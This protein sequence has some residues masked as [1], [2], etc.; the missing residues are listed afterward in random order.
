MI[1]KIDILLI[2]A[3][4][5]IG[6]V[7]NGYLIVKAKKGIDIR[8]TGSGAI[9]ATNVSRVLGTK[10]FMIVS[11]LDVLKGV[12]AVA[13][14]ALITGNPFGSLIPVLAGFLAVLG[15]IFPIWLKFKGGK[16]VNTSL[17][18]A[19]MVF[20]LGVLMA[21]LV[22]AM[23]FAIGK[24]VSAASL[25]AGLFYMISAIV[26]RYYF[27]VDISNAVIGFSIFLPILFILTHKEN[28]KRLLKGKENRF[29]KNKNR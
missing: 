8:D 19:I 7:P 27:K 13:I 15:H 25:S 4:Y 23:V 29:G 9:G 26:M 22:F 2:L 3:G 28:I 1:G 10:Y 16:G 11:L 17:G 6:S 5:L 14:A 21:I 18:V 12:L 20:P 24:F